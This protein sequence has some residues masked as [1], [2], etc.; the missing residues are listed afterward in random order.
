MR[1]NN[2]T[3]ID[4]MGTGKS[5]VAKALKSVYSDFNVADCDSLIVDKS[6]KSIPE[7]FSEDGEDVFRNLESLALQEVLTHTHTI[8][9]TGGGAI[10]KQE[11]RE[12]IRSRS[13]VVWLSAS[14]EM[15]FERIKD[16][17][18]RPL[19]NTGASSENIIERIRKMLHQRFELYR[20]ITDVMINTENLTPD[21]VAAAIHEEIERLK[22]CS[23]SV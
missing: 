11:N 20:E 21:Q 18:H 9:A 15:I 17:A 3:L 16:E 13:W 22:L 7:I 6:G 8:V 12:V 4:F 14:P 19:I 5:S 1:P 23:T 10:L 2:I